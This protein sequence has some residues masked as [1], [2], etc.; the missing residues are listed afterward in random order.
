MIWTSSQDP[1]P[2]SPSGDRM[3]YREGVHMDSHKIIKRMVALVRNFEKN[4]KRYQDPVLWAWLEFF[5]PLRGTNSKTTHYCP[6]Y[7]FGSI[8]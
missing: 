7:F 6:T 4:P 8:P 3:M 5:S 2:G 1:L